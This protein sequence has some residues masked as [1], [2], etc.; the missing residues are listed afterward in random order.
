MSSF[1]NIDVNRLEDSVSIQEY[2]IS[3]SDVVLINNLREKDLFY[4]LRFI[5]VNGRVYETSVPAVWGFVWGLSFRGVWGM[6]MSW[7]FM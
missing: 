5:D 3:E 7:R 2:E 4:Y 6:R 1:L